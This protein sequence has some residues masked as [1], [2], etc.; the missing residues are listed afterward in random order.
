MA[1]SAD[2]AVYVECDQEDL[3]GLYALAERVDRFV[4]TKPP[5]GGYTLASAVSAV[6]NGG[7]AEEVQ[8]ALHILRG[9]SFKPARAAS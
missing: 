8:A 1:S 6:F 5:S 4:G 3:P 7:R 9:W 2:I